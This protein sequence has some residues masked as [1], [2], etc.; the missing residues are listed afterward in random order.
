LFKE[1]I[2]TISNNAYDFIEATLYKNTSLLSG[3]FCAVTLV[4]EVLGKK[5]EKG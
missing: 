2:S 4:L 5:L 1:A 3:V